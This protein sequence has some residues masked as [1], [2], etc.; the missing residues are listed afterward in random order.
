MTAE[1]IK[2]ME[3]RRLKGLEDNLI[4][5]RRLNA[6]F[7]RRTRQGK[8]NTIAKS[9]TLLRKQQAG[10]NKKIIRRNKGDNRSA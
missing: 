5:D 9:I 10:R 3:E 8:E 7:Q 1:T 6:G 2:V 4:E